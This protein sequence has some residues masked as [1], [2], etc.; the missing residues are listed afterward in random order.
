MKFE[1]KKCQKIGGK[2]QFLECILRCTKHVEPKEIYEVFVYHYLFGLYLQIFF[3]KSE[4]SGSPTVWVSTSSA[5]QCFNKTATFRYVNS[6]NPVTF[7]RPMRVHSGKL[8]FLKCRIFHVDFV[9]QNNEAVGAL[10]LSWQFLQKY[11][12]KK[13]LVFLWNFGLL[14]MYTEIFTWKCNID[15][16]WDYIFKHLGFVLG[17]L[18]Q[19]KQIV[20]VWLHRLD[21]R[22]SCRCVYRVEFLA[23]VRFSFFASSKLQLK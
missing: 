17:N 14:L 12:S 11:F 20:L 2:L 6:H 18:P 19:F 9:S 13:K 5:L 16:I 1:S 22:W 10:R 3:F 8:T 7:S 4:I 23:R 21:T 15:C